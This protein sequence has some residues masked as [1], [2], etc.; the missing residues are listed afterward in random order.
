M[1]RGNGT[2]SSNVDFLLGDNPRSLVATDLNNDGCPDLAV[3]LRNSG[4]VQILQNTGKGT[5]LWKAYYSVG[6]YP[7]TVTASDLDMD[8]N[9]DLA[10][11]NESS[12][13]ISVLLN[14]GDGFFFT[15]T[16]Y[17]SGSAPNGVTSTDLDADGDPDLISANYNSSNVSV[18]LNKGD[19]TFLP[20][21]DINA[22][23]NPTWVFPADLDADGDVDLA[24][25]NRSSN[26]VSVLLNRNRYADISVSSD[27]LNYNL[28]ALNQTRTLQF[29]ITNYGTDSTLRITGI[30]SSD[31]AFVTDV[32][33]ANILPGQ[34][35]TIPVRFT[36]TEMIDYTD[37]LIILSNDPD[38][39]RMKI[40]LYGTGFIILDH[41]PRQNESSAREN[42]SI[43]VTFSADMNAA[44]FNAGSFI[45]QG[46]QTGLH[47]GSFSYSSAAKTIVFAPHAPF[48]AG[49]VVAVLLTTKIENTNGDT[50]PRP[51]QWSFHVEA[52]SGTGEFLAKSDF[53]AGSYPRG[54]CLQTSMMMVML[55]WQWP[56]TAPIMF[57]FCL[58]GVT[59]LLW[60]KWT[61]L[62]ETV[63]MPSWLRT[64]T[65]TVT[66]IWRSPITSG[67]M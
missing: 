53:V 17:T 54:V 25:T 11:A 44:T 14:Q 4:E 45:V 9:M 57:P 32:S 7:V 64:W 27:S 47:H 15:S 55:T 5:F 23:Y 37:S 46:S 19:G 40:R 28:T 2:F 8:G 34:N 62:Q 18:L 6:T 65:W 21:T 49:E 3:I 20:K 61:M 66:R 30:T 33:A 50:L 39:P 58:T 41:T 29:V 48:A 24:V 42:T 36:P 63:L 52:L 31:P 38:A 67:T 26:T 22:G 12:N 51:Y 35:L 13:N 10:V 56:I 60:L 16:M 59:G 1:N 43:S